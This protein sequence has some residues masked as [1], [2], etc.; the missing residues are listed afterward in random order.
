MNKKTLIAILLIFTVAVS[1]FAALQMTT[2]A[3]PFPVPCTIRVVPS[4][5][6]A[7]VGSFFVVDVNIEDFFLWG[8]Y[9]YEFLLIYPAA[10]MTPVIAYDGDFLVEP[11]AFFWNEPGAGQ[12]FCQGVTTAGG[13]TGS[14][15]LA[16]IEFQCIGA[17]ST[18][19]TLA[20]DVCFISDV[21]QTQWAPDT[22]IPG[23]VNQFEPPPALVYL[24]PPTYTVPI[25]TPFTV[26][27]MVQ[28]VTDLHSY[29]LDLSYTNTA[30]VDCLDIKDAGFIPQPVTELWKNID[31]VT[32]TI[33]FDVAST[34][35]YGADGSGAIAK[36]TFHCTGGGES[37]L[38]IDQVTL[39]DSAGL[40]ITRLIGTP[41]RYV[42]V[43]YWEPKDLRELVT[44]RSGDPTISAAYTYALVDIPFIP[45]GSPEGYTE[46]MAE[47]TAKGFTFDPAEGTASELTLFTDEYEELHG[48]A[49]SWWSSN[50]L[51][52]GTRACM[53]SLEMDDGTGMAMGFVTNLMPTEQIPEVDPYIIYNAEPYFFID[54]YWYAWTPIGRIVRWSYW[55]HDSHNHPN[56][57]WG[58][59]WWW[60]T[61]TKSYYYP[62][63]DI[64]YWRPVWGWWW[65]WT[66]WKHWHWWSTYFPYIDP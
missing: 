53:L 57:F 63:T 2:F 36:I 16:S 7:P 49:T 42:Q 60:R 15:T 44:L 59:Y 64:P 50:T 13:A 8:V 45:P 26:N 52:D 14:G 61:Y 11:V 37:F 62:Y 28:D 29:E 48:T 22:L 40:P 38:N 6:N 54:F 20:P 9:D 30:V 5:V 32:G 31:D 65:H 51:E 47:L 58:T 23:V 12:V 10:E 1:T 27:V 55:W 41:G 46:V 25:C 66:Y 33:Q 4:V 35:G 17:G 3:Q 24:D 56:W 18:P 21:T 19:I 34:Q 39:Y 43:S